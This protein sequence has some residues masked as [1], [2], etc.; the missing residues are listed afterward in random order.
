[1]DTD[2]LLFYGLQLFS[3][4]K[5]GQQLDDVEEPEDDDDD[6]LVTPDEEE[7][8]VAEPEGD[9]DT[10]TNQAGSKG[11]KKP[12]QS[13]D[14]SDAGKSGKEKPE[15][16]KGDR[17]FTQA[18]VDAIIQR[19]LARERQAP[20]KVNLTEVVSEKG[21]IPPL[22]EAEI[23]DAARLWTYLKAN[24]DINRQV[25]KLVQEG[26]E[27][28]PTYT[29]IGKRTGTQNDSGVDP[30]VRM[31]RHGL[32]VELRVSDPTFKKYEKQIMTYAEANDIDVSTAKG[33]G[34]AYKA[35]RGEKAHLLVANA[36]LRGQQKAQSARDAVD[37]ARGVPRKGNKSGKPKDYRNMKDE[38]VLADMGIKLFDDEE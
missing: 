38:D 30:E 19:R 22:P 20:D 11:S 24:P 2:K 17:L 5:A 33:V 16:Q 29:R 25:N 34:L 32:L 4:P 1:M 28:M 31:E 15:A 37:Q 6:D 9:D 12:D 3:G 8:D 35:W 14:D 26:P 21:S 10:A 23:V 36:E 27:N 13:T 7:D 18:E